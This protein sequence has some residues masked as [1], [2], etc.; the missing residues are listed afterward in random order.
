MI[1][2]ILI[3]ISTAVQQWLQIKDI[4]KN[5][6]NMAAKGDYS[7]WWITILAFDTLL[8]Q[9]SNWLWKL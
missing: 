4:Q 5:E 8:L 7:I 9:I 6:I 2:F 1:S 3:W